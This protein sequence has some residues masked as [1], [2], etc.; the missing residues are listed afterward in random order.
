[1]RFVPIV[2]FGVVAA[3]GL[4]G[5]L[6]AEDWASFRGPRGTGVATD[7]VAPL[8]WGEKTNV[9]WRVALPDRGNST[10]VVWG[11]RVFVTQAIAKQ[12]RRALFAF[13][14]TT[15]KE[16][17]Q[18]G[19]TVEGK[20]PT[21][22]QNPYCS[23]SPATDG[24]RVVAFFGTPG[25][26]CYDRA[27]KELWHRSLG[28]V[29]SWH[30]SGSSPVLHG[31]LCYLNF[32]PGTQ[33]A[34]YA[35]DLKSGEVVWKAAPPKAANS[36]GGFGGPPGGFGS[37]GGGDPPGGTGK[38]TQFENAG[39]AGD[40]SGKGGYNGSWCSPVVLR[41]GDREEL[42][43]VES[44][45]IAAYDPK[46]GKSLWTFKGLP[47]QVFA[48]PAVGD[49][50]LVAMGH[51]APSGTKIIALKLGGQGDVT[52]TNRLW[53]ATVK[54]DCIGSGVVHD[55]C[56]FLVSQSGFALCLDLKTGKKVWEERLPG[57]AGSWSSLVLVDGRLLAANHDGRVSVLAAAREFKVLH[58][59][60][61]PAET[62]CSSPAVANGCV[63]LRTHDALWCFAN[64]K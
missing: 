43:L 22:R 24:E 46:T 8:T 28:E 26:Y 55:G 32:G 4:S 17:W 25:L 27:G 35:V 11:D 5:G 38:P 34:L 39:G 29:D 63:L 51:V 48:S 9:R 44:S 20:E 52:E 54:K 62:T 45:R 57:G 41:S 50:V 33:A 10:P 42:V 15:G 53:E 56:V 61:I 37:T 30:G 60:T 18:A 58:T 1:M 14:L 7:K 13:D 19:V 2:A 64:P 3:F 12:K 36:F 21:N 23:A 6:R 59:N 16:L 49:G 47:D 31:G 40:F